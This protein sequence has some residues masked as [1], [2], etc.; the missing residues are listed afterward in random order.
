MWQLYTSVVYLEICNT[1]GILNWRSNKTKKLNNTFLGSSYILICGN[2]AW[3]SLLVVTI[4]YDILYDDIYYI[5]LFQ[6]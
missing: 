6:I 1:F 2:I 4:S 5:S 3:K